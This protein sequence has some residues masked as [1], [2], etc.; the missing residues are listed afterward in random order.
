MHSHSSCR[1]ITRLAGG[2]SAV[3]VQGGGEGGV[4]AIR[5]RRFLLPELGLGP[6]IGPHGAVRLG[7]LVDLGFS[8][9]ACSFRSGH[10]FAPCGKVMSGDAA[11][12]SFAPSPRHNGVQLE[13]YACFPLERSVVDS[14]VVSTMVRRGDVNSSL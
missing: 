5:R 11:G 6:H 14:V 13:W 8:V 7:V 10:A 9:G 3:P 2:V 1:D 4:V 12:I